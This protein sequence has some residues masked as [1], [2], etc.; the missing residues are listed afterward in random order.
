MTFPLSDLWRVVRVLK[1]THLHKYLSLALSD[2]AL[3]F[4]CTMVQ[5][6]DFFYDHQGNA[7]SV[8]T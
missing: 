6:S 3:A 2:T 8:H 4:S 1:H 7:V 5:C